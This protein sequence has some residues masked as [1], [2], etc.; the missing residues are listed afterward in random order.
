MNCFFETTAQ[1]RGLRI[2]GGMSPSTAFCFLLT[3]L[4]LITALWPANGRLP[5]LSAL[6]A[7]VFGIGA[8]AALGQISNVLFGFHLWNYF[9]MAIHTALGFAL[10]GVGLLA[11]AREKGG[12]R[13]VLRRKISV[14]FVG[15]IAIMLTAAGV[16]WNYTNQ[17]EKTVLEVSHTHEILAEIEDIRADKANLESGQRGYLILGDEK[18]LASR[19]ELKAD[20]RQDV[21]DL[22]RIG[23][24][25]SRLQQWLD[26]LEPL[27]AQR[28][29]FTEQLISTRRQNGFPA[30][31]Q[32]LASGPGLALSVEISRMLDAMHTGEL[33][34]LANR[35]KEADA[36]SKV[37]FLV[38]PVAVF[39]SLTP[40]FPG[41]VFPQRGRR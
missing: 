21:A 3:G 14:A 13:W 28:T 16:S 15:S 39:L 36:A 24:N 4:A 7:T 10:M 2:R 11:Y 5:I 22:R 37:T 29:A 27:M 35:Q 23:A 31:Q 8:M 18:L 40:P 33:D 12:M 30:A 34:L 1:H 41:R 32:L 9:G 26:Q 6:G 20:V 17:L 25:D 19:E 38:L